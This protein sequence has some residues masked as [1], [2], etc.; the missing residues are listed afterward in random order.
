[1]N[2]LDGIGKQV[3]NIKQR[4]Q[5]KYF[6]PYQDPEVKK[7]IKDTNTQLSKWWVNDVIN[8]DDVMHG[9]TTPK[10]TKLAWFGLDSESEFDNLKHPGEHYKFTKQNVTYTFNSKGFRGDEI[11]D[12]SDYTILVVGCSHTFGIGLDD[13]Q[14]WTYHLKENFMQE[15]PKVKVI[16]LSCPGGSND[17]IAR[18]IATSFDKVKPDLVVPCWTYP[19]RR[20]AIWDSGL[21][22]ELNTTVPDHPDYRHEFQSHFMTINEHSDYYNWMRNHWLV[23]AVCKDVTLL[24]THVTEMQVLQKDLQ[25]IINYLDIARDGKHFGPKVH[26]HFGLKIYEKWKDLSKRKRY[27]AY[28]SM[29]KDKLNVK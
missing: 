24:D 2:W 10:N 14:V 4:I 20:E 1:M 9:F 26:A 5:K 17:W 6:T 15:Y 29:Q 19:N 22:W 21:L 25:T 8:I 18:A 7:W 27:E 12:I 16:N 3:F 11:D 23:K 28:K 13:T